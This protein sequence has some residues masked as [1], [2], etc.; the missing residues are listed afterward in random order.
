[1]AKTVI[2]GIEYE[3]DLVA[4]EANYHSDCYYAFMTFRHSKHRVG[5]PIDESIDLAL[6]EIFKH[7]ENNDECQFSLQELRHLQKLNYKWHN[8]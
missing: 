5:R 8:N 3:F 6:E 7:I 1:M 4:T 2:S